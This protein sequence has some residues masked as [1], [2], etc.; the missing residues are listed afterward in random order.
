MNIEVSNRRLLDGVIVLDKPGRITSAG[1]ANRVKRL[2]DRGTKI[3]HAGTLDP[4]ATGILLLL[5]GKATK[6]SQTLMGMPKR[7]EATINLGAGTATD[8]LESPEIP[9]PN[10]PEPAI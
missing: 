8:D 1:A 6:L 5:I 3:G 4:F 7:Y 10:A 2:L 9:A